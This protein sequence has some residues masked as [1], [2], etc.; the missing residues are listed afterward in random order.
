MSFKRYKFED[1]LIIILTLIPLLTKYL[2]KLEPIKPAA[3]VINIGCFKI[4][5]INF[6]LIS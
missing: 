6:N 2:V 4:N 3:P 5:S 1:F